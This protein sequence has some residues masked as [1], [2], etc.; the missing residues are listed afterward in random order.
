[1]TG[2]QK[3]PHLKC[4]RIEESAPHQECNR[5]GAATQS[6]R[7]QVDED[8]PTKSTQSDD[9]GQPPQARIKNREGLS[10]LHGAVADPDAA[11]PAVGF[12]ATIDDQTTTKGRL[13]A[14]TA[15]DGRDLREIH[16]RFVAAGVGLVG[17]LP[18]TRAI[19]V[20]A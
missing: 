19:M 3:L 20:L 2:E 4:A 11:M 6:G 7:L 18:A 14:A 8:R 1:M 5:A 10:I 9:R 16:R 13:G 15:K 12:V 17:Q